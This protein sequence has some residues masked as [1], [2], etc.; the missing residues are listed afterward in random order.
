MKKTKE[1]QMLVKKIDN[2]RKCM[3]DTIDRNLNLTDI[4]VVEVSK[5][6]DFL[7]NEYNELLSKSETAA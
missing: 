1:L 2:T 5:M 6:L 3:Y 7:L 4:E